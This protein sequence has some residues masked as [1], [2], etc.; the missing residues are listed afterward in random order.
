MAG[1]GDEHDLDALAT[2]LRRD[3]VV[4]LGEREGLD[5]PVEREATVAMRRDQL[6]DEG[7]RIAVAFHDPDD[8][9]P[10]GD[11]RG[12]VDRDGILRLRGN[13]D[14]PDHA[15]GGERAERRL[16]RLDPA[17][18]VEGEVEAIGDDAAQRFGD[19]TGL[20]IDDVGRAEPHAGIVQRRKIA[21]IAGQMLL[22]ARAMAAAG[23]AEDDTVADRQPLDSLADL[24]DHACALVAEHGRQ[25]VGGELVAKDEI[26]V[27]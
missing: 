9:L 18:G 5:Q 4:D 27:A 23:K 11:H 3:G 24:F 6:R 25:R 8:A 1:S 10:E 12:D 21:A 22:A 16:D 19:G 26:G 13:A 20:G 14:Q 7:L 17:A 2:R 15:A